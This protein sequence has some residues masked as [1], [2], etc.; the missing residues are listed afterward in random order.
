M[1]NNRE[2]A[3]MFEQ[4]ADMLAI[5]GD[6]FHRILAY[7]KGAESIRGLG[8]DVNVVHAAGELEQITGIGSTLASKIDEMLTTGRLEFYEKLAT[9]VPPQL[10]ELLR[11]E[12]LGPKK[13]KVIY[14]ELGVTTLDELKAAA[15]DGKLRSLSG[16]GR[17]TEEN[18]LSALEALEKH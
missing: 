5:R 8:R 7:R 3:T 10:T 18:I 9:E 4:V 17:K 2:I 14:D 1:M 12:G 11:V 15:E 13:V 6:S 16:M